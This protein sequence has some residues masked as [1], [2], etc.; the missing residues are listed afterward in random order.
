LKDLIGL[1][2]QPVFARLNSWSRAI[3]QY[4]VGYDRF[5]EN[6]AEGERRFPGL[7]TGGQMRDGISLPNCLVAGLGLAEKALAFAAN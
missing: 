4:D 2:G 5:L 3:P 6:I 1:T 7:F